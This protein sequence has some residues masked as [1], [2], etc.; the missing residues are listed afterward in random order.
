[1][2]AQAQADAERAKLHVDVTR[3]QVGRKIRQDL[4]V[5]NEPIT[6]DKV[7]E[8]VKLSDEYQVAMLAQ[9]EA[10]EKGRARST[11]CASPSIV[12]RTPWKDS[13]TCSPPRSEPLLRGIGRRR[14]K[15]D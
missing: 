3:A 2:A 7:E 11:P 5:R 8:L 1:L 4:T 14:P 10:F 15:I 9:I 12:K 13:S 6:E